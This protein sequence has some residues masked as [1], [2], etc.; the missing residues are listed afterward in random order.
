MLD[1]V[2]RAKARASILSSLDKKFGGNDGS[3]STERPAKVHEESQAKENQYEIV[4][5]IQELF[6][7]RSDKTY[8]YLLEQLQD[9][10]IVLDNTKFQME[11]SKSATKIKSYVRRNIRV[12]LL[13]L[14][15]Y[16]TI[17]ELKSKRSVSNTFLKK[18]HLAELNNTSISVA[19]SDFLHFYWKKYIS[20]TI[21]SAKTTNQ[22]Q[23]R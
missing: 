7:D 20:S 18:Q 21:R 1:A 22:I 12:A 10:S 19:N 9:K 11:A 3:C 6:C 14:F 4:Q 5:Q 8:T 23:S 16:F 2:N 17:S 13:F 15:F